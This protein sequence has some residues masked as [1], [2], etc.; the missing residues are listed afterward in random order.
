MGAQVERTAD[1]QG[2]RRDAAEPTARGVKFAAK[3]TLDLSG[4]AEPQNGS[5]I[6][7]A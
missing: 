5:R 2:H 1:E 6:D 4:R 3:A 7:Q